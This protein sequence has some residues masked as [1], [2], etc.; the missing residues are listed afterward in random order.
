MKPQKPFLVRNKEL[1]QVYH[2]GRM[3]HA[4]VDAILD[5]QEG[6]VYSLKLFP[7][8]AIPFL[9]EIERTDH[10]DYDFTLTDYFDPSL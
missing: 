2:W 9:S 1:L 6:E 10:D 3:G 4:S 8:E 7:M 5:R